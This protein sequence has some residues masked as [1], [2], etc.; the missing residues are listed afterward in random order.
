MATK[1]HLRCIATKARKHEEHLRLLNA[2]YSTGFGHCPE[3]ILDCWPRSLSEDDNYAVYN[4]KVIDQKAAD[5]KQTIFVPVQY[6]CH[7][8]FEFMHC[9]ILSD[10]VSETQIKPIAV[11]L[12]V[13]RSATSFGSRVTFSLPES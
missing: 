11:N 6:S 13:I 2:N 7:D 12:R 5:R 8:S 9:K 1:Q 3:I 4:I 10:T